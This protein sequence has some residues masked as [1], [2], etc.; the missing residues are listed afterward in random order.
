MPV[1]G[2]STTAKPSL[3]L[4]TQHHGAFGHRTLSSAA[5]LAPIFLGFLVKTHH[6]LATAVVPQGH[7][8]PFVTMVKLMEDPYHI[9]P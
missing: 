3:P 4:Q 6:G 7:G 9:P 8:T 1:V 2:V 5:G